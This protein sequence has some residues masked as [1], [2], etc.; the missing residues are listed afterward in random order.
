MSEVPKT[1]AARAARLRAEIERANLQYY[2]HD[3]PSIPDV[4]YDR[5][6]RELQDLEKQYPDL[7]AEDSPTLRVGVT[8][9]TDFAQVAHETP[10]L[11]LGNALT[12]DEVEAFDRR[13]REGLEIEGDVEYEVEPKFDGLAVNLR[14]ERGL[15]VIGATRGDGRHGE[16]VT[17]NLRT[18]RSI[19][20][21]GN[22]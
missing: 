7:P 15:L 22:T 18:V 8:P 10:M 14:Y 2:V 4:E 16:D 3:A 17:A 19:P 6:F 9:V 13:V 21:P 11:S 20:F 5:L 1:V 12:N